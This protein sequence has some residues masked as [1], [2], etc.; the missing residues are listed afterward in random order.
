MHY[1]PLQKHPKVMV[2]MY[3]RWAK[4]GDRFPLSRMYRRLAYDGAV[5]VWRLYGRC[6]LCWRPR[7]WESCLKASTS[8]L[9]S[10]KSNMSWGWILPT[11]TESLLL[12]FYPLC[13]KGP[14]SIKEDSFRILLNLLKYC[15]FISNLQLILLM[16]QYYDS[17]IQ[18]EYRLEWFLHFCRIGVVT[19]NGGSNLIWLRVK[20]WRLPI[21]KPL[22]GLH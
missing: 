2:N 6:P 9:L 16:T 7:L 17:F 12:C 10:T 4:R 18:L 5:S 21:S 14:C 15:M 11:S 22:N 1:H 19:Q 13:R 8:L 20:L 3:E